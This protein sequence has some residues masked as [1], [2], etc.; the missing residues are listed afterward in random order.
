MPSHQVPG[1]QVTERCGHRQLRYRGLGLILESPCH[2]RLHPDR[3]CQPEYGFCHIGRFACRIV[4]RPRFE[5]RRMTMNSLDL[6]NVKQL[7]FS[8]LGAADVQWST[9]GELDA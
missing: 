7:T 9:P 3:G 8:P 2:R 6:K 5:W 4:T 1:K